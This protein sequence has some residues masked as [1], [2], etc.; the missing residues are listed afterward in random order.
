MALDI[1]LDREDVVE[2]SLNASPIKAWLE[3][4][5]TSTRLALCAQ[6]AY[7]EGVKTHSLQVVRAMQDAARNSCNILALSPIP[8][9]AHYAK[10]T[11]SY[12]FNTHKREFEI[13]N[14]QSVERFQFHELAD[15]IHVTPEDIN[16]NIRPKLVIPAAS[17]HDE[18]LAQDTSAA[19]TRYQTDHHVLARK[20]WEDLSSQVDTSMNAEIWMIVE[21][22]KL[23]H[24][25]YPDGFD[26]LAICE[27]TQVGFI[28][29]MV[30][31]EE[32]WFAPENFVWI[33]AAAF[34][35][36][37]PSD[38]SISSRKISNAEVDK[39]AVTLPSWVRIIP[40]EINIL[41]FLSQSMDANTKRA[42]DLYSKWLND[43]D[44]TRKWIHQNK[45]MMNG[46]SF[47]ADNFLG[48][49]NE[50]WK[51]D[52]YFADPELQKWYGIFNG[53]KYMISHYASWKY[54]PVV[55]ETDDIAPERQWT[56]ILDMLQEHMRW[57]VVRVKWWHY[58]TFTWSN[59]RNLWYPWIIRQ[60]DGVMLDPKIFESDILY[61]A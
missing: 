23:M 35:D 12:I 22:M 41:N 55:W 56:A 25:R 10:V 34:P 16:T 61:A 36:A 20:S 1:S 49:E 2:S 37:Q 26:V 40:A 17:S 45:L 31:L 3:L 48:T 29:A 46:R 21:A 24:E 58:A 7:V 60:T 33:A 44:L 15:L 52:R 5:T 57:E 59:W 6:E 38:V 53:K 50:L 42:M 19:M 30:C 54:I 14:A 8:E 28:A 51:K 11:E 13:P 43:P 32:Y 9:V 27:W 18:M 39:L 4:Y 47:T